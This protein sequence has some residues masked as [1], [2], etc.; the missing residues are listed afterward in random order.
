MAGHIV[1]VWCVW[2][3]GFGGQNYQNNVVLQKKQTAS[4]GQCYE[5]AI[6]TYNSLTSLETCWGNLVSEPA[7]HWTVLSLALI[8]SLLPHFR[9]PVEQKSITRQVHWLV[10]CESTCTVRGWG[11][12]KHHSCSVCTAGCLSSPKWCWLPG[13]LLDSPG[14]QSALGGWGSC[15]LMAGTVA[16]TRQRRSNNWHLLWNFP[17][18]GPSW[19]VLPTLG[20]LSSSVVLHGNIL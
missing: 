8:T 3:P 13:W 7:P 18:G 16:L 6:D 4:E 20:G 14:L 10:L 15:M 5:L 2:D 12:W 19:E 9:E 11:A 1:H 17:G